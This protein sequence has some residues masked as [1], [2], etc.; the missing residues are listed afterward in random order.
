M[1]KKDG[2]GKSRRFDAD[3]RLY[4]LPWFGYVHDSMARTPR[5][6]RQKYIM[7]SASCIVAKTAQITHLDSG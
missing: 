5:P 3:P 1:N 7:F 6:E 4:H 2:D